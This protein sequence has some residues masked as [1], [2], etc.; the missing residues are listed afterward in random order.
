M[1][2]AQKHQH[3]GSASCPAT[4]AATPKPHMQHRE[5]TCTVQQ[6]NNVPW[7]TTTLLHL[8]RQHMPDPRQHTIVA[9]NAAPAQG[10]AG[11]L[12]NAPSPALHMADSNTGSHCNLQRRCSPPHR[13]PARQQHYPSTVHKVLHRTHHAGCHYNATCTYSSVLRHT[14][15]CC[16]L[17]HWNWSA[18]P[19]HLQCSC[20]TAAGQL[21]SSCAMHRGVPV[22][23]SPQ[24]MTTTTV[25]T[26]GRTS[27]RMHLH[28][29]HATACRTVDFNP[30]A[31]LAHPQVRPACYTLRDRAA[32]GGLLVCVM[33]NHP[34]YDV[35][36]WQLNV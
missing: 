19:H 12:R 29:K 17:E 34:M 20:C 30:G 8:S 9:P 5:A 7:C 21:P 33:C 16:C 36:S 11:T 1:S 2:A 26:A 35:L 14:A 27:Q 18:T 22:P 32:Q 28:T 13:W 23:G 24:N 6:G 3:T 31:Q 15:L 25:T 4:A 10:A